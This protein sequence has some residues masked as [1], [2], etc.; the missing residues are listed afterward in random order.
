MEAKAL[1]NDYLNLLQRAVKVY[2]KQ[3]EAIA[4]NVANV[5]TEGYKRIA[6]DFS[7]ELKGAM[8]NSGARVRNE[9]HILQSNFRSQSGGPG[10]NPEGE[11]D[12]AREMADLASNQIRHE[13]VTRAL[14]RYYSGMTSAITGRIR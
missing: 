2:D 3:H 10:E 12:I 14:A 4:K 8:S 6:T 5:N 13:F 9:K 1:Q 7:S 11:V